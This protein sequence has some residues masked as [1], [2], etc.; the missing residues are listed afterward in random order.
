ML[1]HGVIALC[2]EHTRHKIG[3]LE[4]TEKDGMYVCADP[5]SFVIGG[6]I[7]TVFFSVDEGRED[8]NTTISMPSSLCQGNG[9][10]LTC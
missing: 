2:T 5:E 4:V 10:S 8:S 6:P 3:P 9:V 1:G 7:L